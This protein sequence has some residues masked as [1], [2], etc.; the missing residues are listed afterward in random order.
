MA[1]ST[2][3]LSGRPRVSDEET[4][5]VRVAVITLPGAAD[6][7]PGDSAARLAESLR[8]LPNARYAAFRRHALHLPLLGDGATY[9]TMRLEG[10]R[11]DGT[12]V[13]VFEVYWADLA[14]AATGLRKWLSSA[15]AFSV[16]LLV[17]PIV[18]LNVILL[19]A[20]VA[21]MLIRLLSE[22]AAVVAST[23]MGI[24]T[25]SVALAVFRGTVRKTRL[26]WRALS[27]AAASLGGGVA[28]F[29]VAQIV[30]PARLPV[31]TAAEWWLTAWLLFHLALRKYDRVVPG[32]LRVGHLLY[33]GCAATFAW[34]LALGGEHPAR[35]YPGSTAHPMSIVA[36][37]LVE[38]G[39]LWTAQLVWVALRSIG[40]LVWLLALATAA[41]G[42]V[43][44]RR[45][46]SRGR[47][48][49]ALLSL[50]T[51]LLAMAVWVGA[52]SAVAPRSGAFQCLVPSI[53]ALPDWLE[54]RVL[55]ASALVPCPGQSSGGG[56]FR[57]LFV[58]GAGSGVV[59]TLVLAGLGVILLLWTD[60]VESATW[61]LW[62]A[63]F[64]IPPVFT[65]AVHAHVG[66][67][68]PFSFEAAEPLT[69]DAIG[70]IAAVTALV[71]VLIALVAAFRRPA[72]DRVWNA[73]D[74]GA[75]LPED[76]ELR[77]RLAERYVS[78]L[79]YIAQAGTNAVIVVA[80]GGCLTQL[81][82]EAEGTAGDLGVP[83]LTMETSPRRRPWSGVSPESAERL[84][85]LI[86]RDRDGMTA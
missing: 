83:L 38:Q 17:L 12:G 53:A 37:G 65:V 2:T 16:R 80:R 5:R 45:N 35:Y 23:L 39:T 62:I 9:D 52:Y 61:L 34:C 32:A 51:L 66:A 60:L 67:F 18:L 4:A 15:Q 79:R 86:T 74:D 21:P 43:A 14:R 71:A 19:S 25:A 76:G 36:L 27:I 40:F 33:V 72:L 69:V 49:L 57:M 73:Y 50:G 28:G 10:E 42:F 3:S 26:A 56:Y 6:Q 78:L 31:L 7:Q 41:I 82:K 70:E 63:A 58:I 85:E 8:A 30:G 84:D 59:A 1:D 75:A 47:L 77:A 24:V 48:A 46:A 22:S 13:E 54:R 81:T 20:L 44:A 29:A 11:S 68:L 64:V 55:V